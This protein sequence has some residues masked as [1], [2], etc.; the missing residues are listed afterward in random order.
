MRV[1]VDGQLPFLPNIIKE[2]VNP[3]SDRLPR[4][5]WPAFPFYVFRDLRRIDPA[6]DSN[7]VRLHTVLPPARRK[8]D[9]Q[10]VACR[11]CLGPGKSDPRRER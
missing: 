6:V 7:L 1:L 8:R 5:H 10:I 3:V 9:G 11:G 4:D 2:V